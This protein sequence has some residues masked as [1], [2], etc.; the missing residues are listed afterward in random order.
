[1]ARQTHPMPRLRLLWAVMGLPSKH[2]M[3]PCSLPD[4]PF[5]RCVSQDLSDFWPIATM[6]SVFLSG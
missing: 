2:C 3:L 1:M 6:S 5:S 4:L